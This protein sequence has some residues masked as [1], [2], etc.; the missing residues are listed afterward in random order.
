LIVTAREISDAWVDE[1]RH[2]G[3]QCWSIAEPSNL[4]KKHFE[5]EA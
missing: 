5:I 1:F 4:L 3:L 2:R